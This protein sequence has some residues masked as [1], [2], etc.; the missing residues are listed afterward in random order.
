MN[1]P[2]GESVLITGGSGFLGRAVARALATDHRVVLASRNNARNEEAAH[3]TGCDA[4]PM[5]IT[6]IESVRDAFVRVRPDVV[7]HAAATKFVQLSERF[8]HETLDVNVTG[9]Q[10]IARVAVEHG[11]RAVVAVST[12]KAAPPVQTTYGLSKALME[13]LVCS[14]DGATDTA[15]ACARFG[16]MAWSTGSV[17]PEWRRMLNE[18]GVIGTTGPEM[19]RYI[20]S[21]DE[22]AA[23]VVAV[24]RNVDTV[25][26]GIVSRPMKAARIGDLLAAFVRVRGGTWERL[27]ARPGD[28]PDEVLIGVTEVPW[29]TPIDLDG[30]A[31]LLTR[32]H[33]STAN[34]ISGPLSSATADPLSGAELEAIVCAEPE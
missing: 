10:N 6:N 16:N 23:T 21:V 5:D 30:Q 19:R 2:T 22:A 34:P 8:P 32:F 20:L 1:G 7:I 33:S 26:G 25:R 9:T 14:M 15:F 11:A 13:R 18:T 3:E 24:M 31:Y 29:T 28:A 17:L 27:P 4:I 12:D